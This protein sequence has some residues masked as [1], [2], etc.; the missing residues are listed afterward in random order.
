M[1]PPQPERRID[2]GRLPPRELA[3]LRDSLQE[4]LQGLAQRALALQKVAA[5]FGGSGRA[6]DVLAAQKPGE[7]EGGEGGVRSGLRRRLGIACPTR[8]PPPL[9]P[10]APPSSSPSPPPCTWPAPSP[11]PTAS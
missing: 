8:H 10:Q 2:I 1:P 9:P 3:S 5:Q 11:P 7:E 6:I 4:E